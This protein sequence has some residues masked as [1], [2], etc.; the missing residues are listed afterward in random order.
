MQKWNNKVNKKNFDLNDLLKLM[1]DMEILTF[2]RGRYSN[3]NSERCYI[4]LTLVWGFT[5]RDFKGGD[6]LLEYKGNFI[7]RNET[8]EI[9]KSYCAKNKG[10]FIFDVYW[11]NKNTSIDATHS[12][13]MAKFI[14]D[15]PEKYANC[16]PKTCVVN[17]IPHLLLYAKK[18]IAKD[19]EL[20][21]DYGDSSNQQWRNP[22]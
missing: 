16:Q 3:D 5:K 9:S 8:K 12:T 7:T 10:C 11:N 18:Y 1:E 15:S 17:E 6:P 2:E 20:R 21:Y 19:S 13:C 4:G 14:N 22:F